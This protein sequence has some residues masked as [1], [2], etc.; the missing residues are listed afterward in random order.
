VATTVVADEDKWDI[1]SDNGGTLKQVEFSTD[2]GTWMNIDVSPDGEN[3]VFDLLGDIYLLPIDGGQATALTQSRALDIQPRFSPDGTRISFTSDRD[4]ADNIWT[5]GLDGKDAAQVTDESFRL[6]N[7]ADWAPNGDYLV[8]RKHFTGTRS[9]GAGEMWLFHKDGGAGVQLTERKNQQQD[10]GEPVFS[11]DGRYVYFSEDMT[12]GPFFQYN[13]NANEEI[14]N[15]RRLDLQSGELDTY[16]RGYGGAARPS[17]SPDGKHIAFVRRVKGDTELWLYE[18]STGR[19]FSV[20]RGLEQDQQEAWAIFGVYPHIAWTPDSKELLFWANGKINRLDWADGDHQIVEF[21]V[22]VKLPVVSAIQADFPVAEE[23]FNAKMLRDVVTS[24]DG[25]KVVFHAAGYLWVADP[26]TGQSKRLTDNDEFEYQPAFSPDGKRVVYVAW[27]DAGLAQVKSVTLSGSRERV[28]TKRKGF[29]ANPSYSVDGDWVTFERTRGNDLLGH[30]YGVDTGLFVV[31]AKGS[32]LQKIH[33][34]GRRPQFDAD[35]TGL[36]FLEGYGLKKTF[37]WVALDG[38]SERE[39]YSLKYVSDIVLSPQRDRVAFTEL[40]NAYTV[41]LLEIG[42]AIE[43]SRNTKSIPVTKLAVNSGSNLHWSGD[44][45]S[46]HWMQGPTYFSSKLDAEEPTQQTL[47]VELKVAKPEAKVAYVNAQLITGQR[48]EVIEN[49][50]VLVDGAKIAA[51]GD[52]DL[53]TK[54]YRVVDLS[55]KTLM[56][57]LIDAHA[58]ADHFYQG[59]SPKANWAYLA[60]LAYGVTTIH[61]PSANTNFVFGQA[62]MVKSGAMV[63]PRVYSTGSILYGADGDF[64]VEVNSLEDARAHLQRLKSVGAKSVKSYNQPRRDQRQQINQ[65][66][67][68]LDMLVVMEGGSTFYHNLSM[69]L[70]GSTGV[71]HNIAVA[72]L[73]KDM[74]ELWAATDVGYTPT[75]VV[76][77]G[78]LNAEYYWYQK[79]EVYELEPLVNYVPNDWLNARAIRRLKTPEWDYYF[80]EVAKAAKELKDAGISVQVGGHGQMQGLAMHWEMWSL[81]KGGMNPLDVIH[82]A[83]L[84]GATYVG[85]DQDLGSIEAGKLADM[86]ILDKSPVEDIRNTTSMS[87]VVINGVMR[88]VNTMADALN[89]QDR[90]IKVWHR[91]PGAVIAPTHLRAHSH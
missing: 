25:R 57:G 53:S 37:K 38:K 23:S 86:V 18:I 47:T 87:H 19:Q 60:N 10:A 8:A 67:R 15:I 76:N 42:K 6:L 90:G 64:K 62:E 78:G 39:V 88:D 69:I 12:P 52:A 29:Y 74:R 21:S 65:A 50:T 83:T 17:P 11:P 81:A 33:D 22:D 24:P 46:L 36:Y 41:P 70:D 40:F 48:G 3:I 59:I 7:N 71:E 1:E 26:K 32:Q 56:P 68:E 31:S 85:L 63:G 34:H 28:L 84:A 5:M 91:E 49:A 82:S 35:G 58:H 9:L 30:T 16:I 66:A 43:L 45:K 55:G 4:G 20:Y 77:Y 79:D 61:D 14:Y 2:E 27:T 89:K 73:Y 44:A 13:K 75:L 72:P 51:V 80:I 54:G